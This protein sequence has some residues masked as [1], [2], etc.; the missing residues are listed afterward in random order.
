MEM[1]YIMKLGSYV[2]DQATLV[3][4]QKTADLVA[5]QN[6]IERGQKMTQKGDSR[7][8]QEMKEEKRK[9]FQLKK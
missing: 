7:I 6:S 8:L 5:M 1:E 3:Q 4:K 9:S 2:L